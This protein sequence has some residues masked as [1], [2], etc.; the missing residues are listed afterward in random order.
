[1]MHVLEEISGFDE[2]YPFDGFPEFQLIQEIREISGIDLNLI[3]VSNLSSYSPIL[4][5]SRQLIPFPHI[6]VVGIFQIIGSDS[7]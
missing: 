4:P 3:P 6:F 5:T 1:M 7:A 2:I